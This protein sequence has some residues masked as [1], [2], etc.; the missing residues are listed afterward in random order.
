MRAALLAL[1]LTGC[2]SV[3]APQRA[4]I[5]DGITTKLGLAAGG[6]EIG[7]GY[8]SIPIRLALNE[9]AKTL[10]DEQ[11]VPIQQAITAGGLCASV[12]NGA[13]LILPVTREIAA[14]LYLGCVV[15]RWVQ[16]EEERERA[17]FLAQCNTHRITYPNGSCFYKGERL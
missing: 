15:V 11:R 16:G 10:P 1:L 5:A 13:G 6:T 4:V 12:V 3:D 8:A 14:S 9:H 7:A 2:A 17:W